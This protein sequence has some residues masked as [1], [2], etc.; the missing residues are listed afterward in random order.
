MM[1]I[2]KIC[3]NFDKHGRKSMHLCSMHFREKNGKR[4]LKERIFT[5]KSAVWK[6]LFFA[7]AN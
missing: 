2:N 5:E 1:N 6:C 7:S 3:R 4:R